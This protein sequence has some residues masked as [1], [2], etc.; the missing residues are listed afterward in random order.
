MLK[1]NFVKVSHG[2]GANPK[3]PRGLRGRKPLGLRNGRAVFS[4]PQARAMLEGLPDGGLNIAHEAVDRHV[5]AGRGNRIAM[6]WIGRDDQIRDFTY[7]VTGRGRQSV[8]QCPYAARRSQGGSGILAA[9]PRARALHRR[10]RHA[11]ERQRVLAAVF[12]VRA[13]ADQSPHDDRRCQSRWS[14]PRPSTGARSSRGA[15]S[16]RAC[17]MSS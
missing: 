10:A 3:A 17:S 6:R 4:W 1:T 15:T 7:A 8:C 11:E 9:R 13:G 12:G 2:M 16:L 5:R 14:H